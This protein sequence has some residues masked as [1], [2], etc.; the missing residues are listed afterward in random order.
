M[1]NKE[2]M[3][4]NQNPKKVGYNFNIYLLYSTHKS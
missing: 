1:Q 2:K 3:T 4:Q